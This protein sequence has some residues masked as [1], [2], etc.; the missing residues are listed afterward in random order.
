LDDDLWGCQ[1]PRLK[2]ALAAKVAALESKTSEASGRRRNQDYLQL[3]NYLTADI[4]D[5]LRSSKLNSAQRLDVVCRH[6]AAL[7]LRCPSEK[8]IAM[9]LALSHAMYQEPY[10]DEKLNLVN[11]YR[12]R[13]GKHMALPATAE[14]L[15]QLPA[16]HEDLPAGIA[17]IA[18]ASGCRVDAPPK[19]PDFR[20]VAEAWPVRTSRGGKDFDSGRLGDKISLEQAGYMMNGV[21][22]ALSEQSKRE[23]FDLKRSHSLLPLEDWKDGEVRPPAPV[24]KAPAEESEE[25]DAIAAT[26][27][28]LRDTASP[29]C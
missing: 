21:A 14:H 28:A 8:S 1:A 29:P 20:A 17:A 18:F 27:A 10:E 15:L 7:G 6:A 24:T 26:L 2:E 11:Q 12:A 22:R 16:K 13:I 4:W 25:A 3:P 5:Q 19:L 9:L 23:N